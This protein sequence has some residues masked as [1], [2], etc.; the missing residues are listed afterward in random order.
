MNIT[1]NPGQNS[2]AAAQPCCVRLEAI[3]AEILSVGDI[4]EFQFP[5]SWLMLNG[6]SYTR[7]I[8]T[9][10]EYGEHYVQV[11]VP[12]D[13]L[14]NHSIEAVNLHY[15]E[16]EARHERRVSAIITEGTVNPG[17][18]LTIL[19]GNT[20]APTTA[21]TEQVWIAINGKPLA[22]L[23]SLTIT[24]L[25][26]DSLRIII[27]SYADPGETFELLVV[28]LD[29]YKN[30]SSTVYRDLALC[31]E[32]G[33]MIQPLSFTGST[34][35]PMS[36][37]N[38][39]V[40]RFKVNGVYSNAIKI[41][42]NAPK[43]YWGDLHIHTKLSCDAK[44]NDPFGYARNVSGLNFA[45]AADHQESM[46]S[47]GYAQMT[48]WINAIDKPGSFVPIPAVEMNPKKFTGHHN[49]YFRTMDAFARYEISEKSRFGK[50]PE[51]IVTAIMQTK[52][53]DVMV[54]P[55]HTGI[56]WRSIKPDTGLGSAVDI[57]AWEDCGLR[58]VMEIYSHHGQSEYYAPHHSLA[59]EINRMRRSERRSNASVNGP[60][61]A[62]DY[63]IKGKKIGVIASSDEHFGQGGRSHGGITAVYTDGLTR[64][65]IFDAI[66]NR[67]C[68]G[69]TGER[70]LMEFSLNGIEMGHSEKRPKGEKLFIKLSIWGTAPIIRVDILRFRFDVDRSF[71]PIFSDYPDNYALS[72]SYEI[73]DV[74]ESSCMYYARITQEP[75][76]WP[77]MAWSSP[78]WLEATGEWEIST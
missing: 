28:S 29:C 51:T 58:P 60:Y 14:I 63:W 53:S 57:D 41:Q 67:R 55:H 47:A 26:A 15:P 46:G 11:L 77:D 54:V 1:F 34:R 62:Q 50:N 17:E 59:Y 45:A 18:K 30:C 4:I 12:H 33:V 73:T 19:Y 61:Y 10:D 2:F 70:I 36:L 8:Q 16:G 38:T 32:Y 40:Y 6:P 21:E 3:M 44:G 52:P 25:A 43:L 65:N 7:K 48:E 66:V 37:K 64:E 71:T 27:P 22:T 23:P 78:I 5:N 56:A 76:E 13:V 20:F 9:E 39:G 75:L 74:M 69:T 35:I 72:A 24:A 42:Q 31:D 49:F 68:Y